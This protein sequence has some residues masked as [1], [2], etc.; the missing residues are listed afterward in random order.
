MF[1]GIIEATGVITHLKTHSGCT[2]FTIEAN[3]FSDLSIGESIAVNGV[4]LTVTGVTKTTFD[5]TIVPETLR[6]TNL[7]FLHP[8]ILVNLERSLKINTRLSGHF[9]QGHIDAV[10]TILDLKNEGDKALLCT[11][12]LPVDL[13]KFVVNKGY[14]ALDGMSITVIA[15]K[16]LDFTVTF[17]PHTQ[18]MTIIHQYGVGSKINIEVDIL[19]K[20]I[21]EQLGGY[22]TCN[23]LLNVSNLP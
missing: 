13:K 19:G 15:R 3:G 18:Q 11:I 2:H 16:D 14:I 7:G 21:A 20:Y 1:N 4:C 9:V 8:G 12:R 23:P 10:G 22:L 17:I 6:V 5:V